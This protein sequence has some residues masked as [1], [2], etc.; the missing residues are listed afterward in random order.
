MRVNL[1]ALM[2][3]DKEIDDSAAWQ[4]LGVKEWLETMDDWNPKN[5]EEFDD[6][7][8]LM[9]G[10]MVTL[11][12][13]LKRL[14][15]TRLKLHGNSQLD[16][17]LL[18]LTL[19]EMV[20]EIARRLFPFSLQLETMEDWF[21]RE[22]R[23]LLFED[24][25]NFLNELDAKRTRYKALCRRWKEEPVFG[26]PHLRLLLWKRIPTEIRDVLDMDEEY[27]SWSFEVLKRKVVFHHGRQKKK[28]NRESSLA[29][30]KQECTQCHHHN[31]NCKQDQQ[32]HPVL[33]QSSQQLERLDEPPKTQW[34]SRRPGDEPFLTSTGQVFQ[35]KNRR[36]CQQFAKALTKALEKRELSFNC[37]LSDSDSDSDDTPRVLRT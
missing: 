2:N 8:D 12:G 16:R 11:E 13:P 35:I 25:P 9:R 26:E 22:R 1:Y 37:P 20:D 6:E 14:V 33:K 17:S 30:E 29:Q 19:D 23:V 4:K 5:E 34:V 27:R 21:F 10:I 31:L 36:L 7:V 32:D 24:V 28:K 3:I 18:D 15:Y